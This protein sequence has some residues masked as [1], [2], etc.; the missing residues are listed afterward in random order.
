[1]R[2]IIITSL[3]FALAFPGLAQRTKINAARDVTGTL[4]VANG[5][6]GQSSQQAAID[7]L[8]PAQTGNS[9]K[10]LST[11]GTTVSWAVCGGGAGSLAI[12]ANGS[13]VGSEATLNFIP[14]TGITETITDAGTKINKTTAVDTAVMLTR[15][16]AQSGVDLL[17]AP[18]SASGANYTCAMTPALSAYTA[19]M[20][21]QFKP[22][23]SSSA[24]AV[25]LNINSLGSLNIK[26]SDGTT[27]PGA[28]GLVAGRQVPLT[29]DGTVLR[30]GVA[31][32]GGGSGTVT[33]VGLSVPSEFSV[34]GSPV[35]SSGTLAVTK[36]SQS[37]NQVYAGPTTGSAVAPTFRALVAADLPN[38]AVTPG[39]YTSANI[40]V[41]AQGRLTAAANGSGGGMAADWMDP[42]KVFLRDE[43]MGGGTGTGPYVGSELQWRTYASG[44]GSYGNLIGEANH[45]GIMRVTT[46]ATD[47]NY[48][49]FALTG[50][51]SNA[52][53]IDPTDAVNGAQDHL[54]VVRPVDAGARY[55]IGLLKG[56][57]DSEEGIFLEY[58][59][60]T[61]TNWMFVTSPGGVTRT[62]TDSGVPFVANAWVKVRVFSDTVGGAKIRV[63]ST[64]SANITATLP[65]SKI[66]P[67]IY[68]QTR[69]AATKSLDID[70]YAGTS[71]ITR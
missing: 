12:E 22:D 43:F 31:G 57:F 27:D 50:I 16:Q 21:I 62:R 60:D 61:D 9:G 59:S 38:T 69:S 67:G 64:T 3:F 13:A 52:A 11:D 15:A 1:M 19:G 6:T 40:T 53:A 7:A 29:Y 68:I 25:T 55:A 41:D 24:G 45:P 14:G 56:E 36:A 8:V 37:A 5:G 71:T 49:V 2:L 35:T 17:C 30:M 18:A 23:V 4:P 10:C 28:T 63:N 46:S 65:D 39:S 33:S 54:F 48:Q 70:F 42:T 58:D 51:G 44:T 32:S 26:Q 66:T 34:S 47:D 20:V